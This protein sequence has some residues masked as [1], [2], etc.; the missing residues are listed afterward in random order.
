MDLS[1]KQQKYIQ[2][3]LSSDEYANVVAELRIGTSI[4]SKWDAHMMESEQARG[5]CHF[6]FGANVM[7]EGDKNE[8]SE[9]SDYIIQ[10]PTIIV[11][12]K[13]ICKDGIFQFK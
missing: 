12:G 9:H 7:F 11:D 3:D 2:N 1:D 8:S 10:K 6:G 13:Y 5:T 4:N